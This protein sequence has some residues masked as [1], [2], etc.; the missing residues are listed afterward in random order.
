MFTEIML[1]IGGL[2]SLMGLLG[3]DKSPRDKELER[4]RHMI[5]SYMPWIR[6]TPYSKSEVSNLVSDYKKAIDT[7]VGL[8]KSSLGSSLFESMGAAG[9]PAGQPSASM[10]VSEMAPLLAKGVEQKS[11]VDKW[12]AEFY[13]NM[14]AKAKDSLLSLLSNLSALAPYQSGLSSGQSFMGSFL[15]AFNLLSSG[16]GNL[17]NLYKSLNM[18]DIDIESIFSKSNK[19]LTKKKIPKIQ[20]D[21]EEL[22]KG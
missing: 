16:A 1:G 18:K 9:V 11:N 19:S 8:Y 13:A 2:S 22:T 12:G 17:A 10:Y 6:S 7:S 3:L 5:E 15:N 4:I 20:L 14:E 21:D